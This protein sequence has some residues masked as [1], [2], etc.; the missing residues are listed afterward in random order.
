MPPAAGAS[1]RTP[2]GEIIPPGPPTRGDHPLSRGMGYRNFVPV[3]R[4]SEN[5]PSQLFPSALSGKELFQLLAE[6][7]QVCR[8]SI[9]TEQNRNY[10]ESISVSLKNISQGNATQ[11]QPFLSLRIAVGNVLNQCPCHIPP[12]KHIQCPAL[13]LYPEN[14]TMVLINKAI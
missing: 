10:A 2:P 4:R 3:L 5:R 1:P 12:K 9:L 14:H 6:L 11:E 7:A 13:S 8:F